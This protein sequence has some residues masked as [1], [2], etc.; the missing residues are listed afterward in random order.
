MANLFETLI[1]CNTLIIGPTGTGKTTL[2][3]AHK[4]ELEHQNH[5]TV[6]MQ[7]NYF[8]EPAGYQPLIQHLALTASQ[9]QCHCILD[10]FQNGKWLLEFLD[11][12]A[13]LNPLARFTVSVQAIQPDM[14]LRSEA[15]AKL[16]RW[17]DCFLYLSPGRRALPVETVNPIAW[18]PAASPQESLSDFYGHQAVA[19][20]ISAPQNVETILFQEALPPFEGLALFEKDSVRTQNPFL[21]KIT[22]E[23]GFLRRETWG[24]TA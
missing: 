19:S 5:P 23:S 8:A 2:L 9:T 20:F 18:A 24:Q 14:D 7:W 21:F 3:N 11:T 4:A 1:R 6:F 10:G 12:F 22:P 15:F 17:F 13:S 16:R